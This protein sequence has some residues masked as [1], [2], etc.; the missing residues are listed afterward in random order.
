MKFG[1]I[2]RKEF[3]EEQQFSNETEDALKEDIRELE[4]K[5]ALLL[6]KKPATTEEYANRLADLEVKMAKLWTVLVQ[7]DARGKD[8]PS[9]TARKF[10]GGLH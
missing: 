6:E 1:F 2:T 4:K 5:Y 10:F 9:S 3:E 8:K 7:I